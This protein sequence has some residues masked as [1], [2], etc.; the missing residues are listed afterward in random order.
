MSLARSWLLLPLLLA[1]VSLS[2]TSLSTA[3]QVTLAWDASVSQDALGYKLYWSSVSGEYEASKS[4]DVGDVLQYTIEVPSGTFFV[5]TAYNATDESG[6][7]NEV[8][9]FLLEE[10]E[11]ATNGELTY[12]EIIIPPDEFRDT[13]DDFW[14]WWFLEGI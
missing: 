10:I 8:Y 6:Y 9:F 3:A 12:K 11:P 7:S 13:E 2:C 14:F 1:A 4:V 5:A